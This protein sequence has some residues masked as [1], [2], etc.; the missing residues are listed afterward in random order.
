LAE[1][2]KLSERAFMIFLLFSGNIYGR[3]A[4]NGMGSGN[5]VFSKQKKPSSASL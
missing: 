1:E 3:E 4:K 2:M 5:G